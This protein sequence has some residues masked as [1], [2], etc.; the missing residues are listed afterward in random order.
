MT[1]IVAVTETKPSILHLISGDQRLVLES[2][3][4]RRLIPEAEDVFRSDIDSYFIRW[5]L[6]GPGVATPETQIRVDEA[7]GESTSFKIISAVSGAWN[8]KW[9]SQNQVVDFCEKFRGWLGQSRQR[10]QLGQSE[11]RETVTMFLVKKDENMPIDEEDPQ[12][13][14]VLVCVTVNPNG[15]GVCVYQFTID[16]ACPAEYRYR[17][18]SPFHQRIRIP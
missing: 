3:S 1:Q 12:S 5:G 16:F 8:Q 11:Q 7:V 18:V 2:L 17:V 15:L 6:L 10:G 4:G 13:N 14:L 9:L